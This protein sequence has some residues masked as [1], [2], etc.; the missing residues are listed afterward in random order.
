M[1]EDPAGKE[2]PTPAIEAINLSKRYT[3]VEAI[4]D[5]SFTVQPGEIV[6]FLGPNGA[7]KS[8]TLR[9]LCG[10]LPASSGVARIHGH[11]IATKPHAIKRLIGYMPENNPLPEDLRVAEYLRFRAALKEI[12]GK[13]RRKRVDEA[14]DLCDLRGKTRRKLIATLSKG[15]RQR[16]GIADAILSEPK[17]AILD[18]PTIGLDPHQ[19]LVIRELLRSLRGRMTLLLSSHILSE[20][21]ACCDRVVILNQ[22]RVVAS[23]TADELRREFLAFRQYQVEMQGDTQTFAKLVRRMEPRA[24]FGGLTRAPLQDGYRHLTIDV[25]YETDVSE[26]ILRACVQ[27]PEIRLRAFS[28][29]QPSLEDIFLSATRKAGSATTP[30]WPELNREDAPVETSEPVR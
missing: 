9:I 24:R 25:P 3:R 16:V 20:I 13:E 30:P 11:T 4:R 5:I 22:G 15:F 7:G 29:R 8:T 23:G 6:G 10:T 12:P 18:E 17:V 19:I 26:P 21:E 14:L 1:A 2:K 28:T 27:T